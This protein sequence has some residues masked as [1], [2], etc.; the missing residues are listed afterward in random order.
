[1]VLKYEQLKLAADEAS[2]KQVEG[3]RKLNAD[4][5]AAVNNSGQQ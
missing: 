4:D 2:A 5:T 1:M 3:W